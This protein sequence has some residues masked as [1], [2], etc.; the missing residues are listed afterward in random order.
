MDP[1][2]D[3]FSK[4]LTFENITAEIEKKGYFTLPQNTNFN[5]IIQLPSE[6]K[7]SL[8][9]PLEDQY[10]TENLGIFSVNK[11]ILLKNLVFY[12]NVEKNRTFG[13]ELT[14]PEIIN[15]YKDLEI[16]FDELEIPSQYFSN[17][18]SDEICT[19]TDYKWF[20][21]DH[22]ELAEKMNLL[23]E[24]ISIL[25]NKTNKEFLKELGLEIPKDFNMMYLAFP[26]VKEEQ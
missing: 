25:Q 22:P 20:F 5:L 21:K 8:E 15:A 10:P 9:D 17:G 18:P 12:A 13:Y 1:K 16:W 7:I 26:L 23:I 19:V 11:D 3:I 6:K 24:N 2:D 4:G 14:N